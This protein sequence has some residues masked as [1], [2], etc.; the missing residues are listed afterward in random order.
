MSAAAIV[1]QLLS[2]KRTLSVSVVVVHI[3]TWVRSFVHSP[4]QLHVRRFTSL[5]LFLRTS[6]APE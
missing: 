2:G 5:F 3:Y 6:R 4:V 1:A